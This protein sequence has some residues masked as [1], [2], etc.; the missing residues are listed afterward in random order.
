MK[1]NKDNQ[2]FSQMYL[3]NALEGEVKAWV[4]QGWPGVT[5]TTLELFNL[6]VLMHLFRYVKY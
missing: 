2:S 6:L 3:A 5:Q 1:K 4:E